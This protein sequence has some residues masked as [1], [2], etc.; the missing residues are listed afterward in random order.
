MFTV[1]DMKLRNITV[2]KKSGGAGGQ[3]VVC[4]YD[5]D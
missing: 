5:S 3:Y 1:A 2:V 4:I